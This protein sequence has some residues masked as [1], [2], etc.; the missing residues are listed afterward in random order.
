MSSNALTLSNTWRLRF[1]ESTNGDLV[2]EYY[3]GTAWS[4]KSIISV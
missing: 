4:A 2:F 1:D 3:D